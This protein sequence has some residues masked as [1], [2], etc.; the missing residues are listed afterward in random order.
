MNIRKLAVAVGAS[1]LF[2]AGSAL[3]G[4]GVNQGDYYDYA[5]VSH[6][7]PIVKIIRVEEPRQECYTEQVVRHGSRNGYQSHT[8]MILG[9]VIGAALGNGLSSN[10]HRTAWTIAGTILG[11]SI[12]HDVGRRHTAQPRTVAYEQRCRNV[13]DVHEIEKVT[14]YR[15]TYRYHG[16]SYV[17]ETPYDPGRKLRIRVGVTPAVSTVNH[18]YDYEDYDV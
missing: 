6:V 5:K 16:R 18:G 2:T 11:G 15:V 14:G 12:G 1:L 8:P 17:T 7:E 3:A 13:S 9:G 10:S 4:H